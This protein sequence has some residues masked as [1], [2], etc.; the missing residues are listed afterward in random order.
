MHAFRAERLDRERGRQ[1]RV[2]AA[3]D[4]DDDLAEA[5]L[6]DVVAQRELEREAH[7]LQV[8]EERRDLR[9]GR[10]AVRGRAWC[11]DVDRLQVERL[12]AIA[13]ERPAAD[14]PQSAGDRDRRLD[15]D[16]EQRLLEARRAGEHLAVVVEHDRVAVEDELVLAADGVARTR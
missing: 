1:R 11:A 5:V 15:V 14:V 13:R 2:D 9:L 12:A 7:L 8:V 10:L 6:V 16:D 3:R 4:A